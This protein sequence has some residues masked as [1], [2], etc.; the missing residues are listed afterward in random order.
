[1][2]L[3]GDDTSA[4]SNER[5]HVVEAVLDGELEHVDGADPFI[6]EDTK[7]LGHMVRLRRLSPQHSGNVFLPV[8]T[9]V[10][11][12]PTKNAGIVLPQSPQQKRPGCLGVIRTQRCGRALIDSRCCEEGPQLDAVHQPRIPSPV[13]FIEGD[14]IRLPALLGLRC[15]SNAASF[16]VGNCNADKYLEC[17]SEKT[18]AFPR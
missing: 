10:L 13:L 18:V 2:V 5:G 6:A 9:L 8:D 7:E 17:E 4:L 1:M 16:G 11:D 12:N 14:E 15:N 3:A